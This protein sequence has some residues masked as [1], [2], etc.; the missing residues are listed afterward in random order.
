MMEGR[1]RVSIHALNNTFAEYSDK[2]ATRD[3]EDGMKIS[4]HLEREAVLQLFHPLVEHIRT[5]LG[6]FDY[7]P[8]QEKGRQA[9]H[10]AKCA[11]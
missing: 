11:R 5:D 8:D 10:E 3:M 9:A 2:T 4:P 7:Q 6:R 1:R